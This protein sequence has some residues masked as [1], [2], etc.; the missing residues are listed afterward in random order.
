MCQ[1]DDVWWSIV[2][3]IVTA[4]GKDGRAE[5]RWNGCPVV[6]PKK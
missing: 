2:I 6:V 4:V 5:G 1:D 3:V